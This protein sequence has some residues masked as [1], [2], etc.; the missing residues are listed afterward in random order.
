VVGCLGEAGGAQLLE[1]TATAVQ[2]IGV[3]MTMDMAVSG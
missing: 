2:G 1:F 3:S